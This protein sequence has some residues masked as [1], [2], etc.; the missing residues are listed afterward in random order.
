MTDLGQLNSQIFSQHLHSKFHIK[1]SDGTS[2]VL[3]LIAVEERNESPKMELF[4]LRFLGPVAP[5]LPQQIHHMEHEALRNIELF[6]TAVGADPQGI[7]YE[8]V[9]HRFRKQS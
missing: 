5:R 7:E 9:F 8:A 6:L 3:S 4:F 2:V 1:N